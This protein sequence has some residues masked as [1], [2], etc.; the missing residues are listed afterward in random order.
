MSTAI[1]KDERIHVRASTS[2]KSL[3]QEA[4]S[5][6]H[7]NLSDFLLETALVEAESVLANRRKFDL[8]ESKWK[9]FQVLLDRSAKSKP[10][11]K[12]LLTQPGVFD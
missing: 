11:L 9:E 2:A 1:L 8:T 7:K 4:A 12:K 10:R 6:T 5:V 3:L